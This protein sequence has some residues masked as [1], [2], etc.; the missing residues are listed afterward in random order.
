MVNKRDVTD[1]DVVNI[2][3]PAPSVRLKSRDHEQASALLQE[4]H[5]IPSGQ[6]HKR[7]AASSLAEMALACAIDALPRNPWPVS[8]DRVQTNSE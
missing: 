8:S 3:V 7:K 4:G 6:G 1:K 2:A 5:I